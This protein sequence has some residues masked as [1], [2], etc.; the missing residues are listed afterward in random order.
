M[1]FICFMCAHLFIVVVDNW[2]IAVVDLI[3]SD[4]TRV[5]V[6]IF[7]SHVVRMLLEYS[8]LRVVAGDTIGI[9]II[10]GG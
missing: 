5:F 6:F 2:I 1:C 4:F 7:I 3:A 8:Q 10:S 9:V